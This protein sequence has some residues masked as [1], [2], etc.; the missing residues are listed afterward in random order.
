MKKIVKSLEYYRLKQILLINALISVDK[1][2]KELK[3]GKRNQEQWNKVHDLK[4]RLNN[5]LKDNYLNYQ[6]KHFEIHGWACF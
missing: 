4:D 2:Y 3:Q 6:D 1:M 5:R